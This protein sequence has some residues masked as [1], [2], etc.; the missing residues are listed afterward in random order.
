MLISNVVMYFI[1]LAS[2]AVLHESGKTHIDTATEAAEA[3]RPIAGAGA[4][5]LMALGLIGTGILTVPI[6]MGS[7]G[8][9]VAEIFGWKCGLDEKPHAAKGFY[10]VIAAATVVAMAINY[11]GIKPMD[12]LFWTAVI[13]GFFS[14]AADGDC[15]ADWQRSKNNG[16]PTERSR[17]EFSGVDGDGL[18]GGGCHRAGLHLGE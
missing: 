16:T 12:A 15:H 5:L 10:W 14:A 2:A 1:I 18:H 13:N 6:L 4:Y 11:I 9:S 3:L 7:A 8:Y 17:S